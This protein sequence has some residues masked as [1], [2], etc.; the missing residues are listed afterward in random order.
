MKKIVLI[1]SVLIS[2]DCYNQIPQC[3]YLCEWGYAIDFDTYCMCNLTIDTLSNQN[4]IWAIGKPQKEIFDQSH[5]GSNSIVTGLYEKYPINDTSCFIL[6]NIAGCGFGWPHTVALSGYYKCNSDTLEDYGL[7]EFS[8]DNGYT[9]IDLIND[10]K[11]K[12]HYE[13]ST[14]KPIF[15]GN[16]EEW[17]YFNVYFSRLGP[18]FSIDYGDTV[19]IRF[20]FISDSIYDNKEGL[21]FDDI[22]YED[23]CEGGINENSISFESKVFPN[24]TN[25]KLTIEFK[26]DRKELFYL[27]IFNQLGKSFL[28][29]DDVNTDRY[30]VSVEQF[31]SGVYY[32]KLESFDHEMHSY[33]SFVV[34][35]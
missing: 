20:C 34:K 4:N 1:I 14:Q 18:I 3:D 25:N 26:N 2:I 28:K 32:Y 16:I 21:I 19:L 5:S 6:N 24:P 8:P 12:D 11:Y 22:S 31:Q 29:I 35:K 13:W 9:W 23:W 17:T 10:A 30:E 27:I 15:T 33:G 7:V